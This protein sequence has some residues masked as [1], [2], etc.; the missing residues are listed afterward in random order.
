MSAMIK[1]MAVSYMKKQHNQGAKPRTLVRVGAIV[2]LA[3]ILT[4]LAWSIA[5]HSNLLAMKPNEFG[6]L[7]AGIFS[8]LAFLWLVLGYFQQGDELRASVAALEL[9][10]EEL[11]NSV[12]Q[13]KALVEVSTKQLEAEYDAR[14]VAEATATHQAQPRFLS[15]VQTNRHS[16]K[17]RTY[18]F[19]IENTGA[20]CSALSIFAAGDEQTSTPFFPFGEQTSFQIHTETD[21]L[22]DFEGYVEYT[23]NL[24]IRRRQAFHVEGEPPLFGSGQ[25]DYTAQKFGDELLSPPFENGE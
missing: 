18:R 7:L 14:R 6:D 25:W 4:M 16:S 15:S 2:S 23:D 24:G 9:Q 13:Q 1:A 12:K 20:P 11:R 22:E 21:N 19:K 5:E 17:S 3:Y 8:P 10:G